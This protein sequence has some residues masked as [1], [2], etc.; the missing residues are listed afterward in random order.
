MARLADDHKVA[1]IPSKYLLLT[2][3]RQENVDNPANLK[4]LS[5]HLA[6]L[7]HNVVFPIHPRTRVSMAKHKIKL[8]DNVVTIDAVGYLEFL[9]LL[10]NCDVVMTDSGGVTEESIILKKP[11]ITLRHSTARWETILLKGNTLFPLDRKDSLTDVIQTMMKSKIVNN[12]YGEDVSA[13]TF[14]LVSK[15]VREKAQPD[16]EELTPIRSSK[17]SR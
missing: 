5:K 10:K 12:P 6:S 17:S 15:I 2:M 4:L 9:Y 14:D 7:K 1:G 11:C 16:V 3:H 13:R 8:P